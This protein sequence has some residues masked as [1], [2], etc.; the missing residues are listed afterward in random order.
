MAIEAMLKLVHPEKGGMASFD[1]PTVLEF[2]L[3]EMKG[4][5]MREYLRTQSD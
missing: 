4:R 2:I 3:K 5:V 1:V